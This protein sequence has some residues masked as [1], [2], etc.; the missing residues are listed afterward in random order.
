MD[1]IVCDDGYG[2]IL[3]IWIILVGKYYVDIWNGVSSRKMVLSL[4]GEC[5]AY[6]WPVP[7]FVW[8]VWLT[9]LYYTTTFIYTFLPTQP[10]PNS[11]NT[12]P[13]NHGHQ[14]QHLVAIQEAG[15]LER[16]TASPPVEDPRRVNWLFLVEGPSGIP[17]F[18][19][20]EPQQE[21][22]RLRYRRWVYLR[23]RSS[24]REEHIRSRRIRR[25]TDT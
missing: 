14:S 1:W 5:C 15:N 2:E 9:Y 13:S 17:R 18:F 11:Q 20:A 22:R 19:A 24:A 3:E 8:C 21:R 23:G 7:T 6:G 25:V 10:Q 12:P 4:W 16:W